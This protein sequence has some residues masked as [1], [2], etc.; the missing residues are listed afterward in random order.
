M[1]LGVV[2]ASEIQSGHF[3]GDRG[4]AATCHCTAIPELARGSP[5]RHWHGGS[6]A[7][8]PKSPLSPQAQPLRNTE[9][10][11]LRAGRK[12][13]VANREWHMGQK[14]SHLS[15]GH[16]TLPWLCCS[17][18]IT[19]QG[20]RDWV[21]RPLPGHFSSLLQ[22]LSALPLLCSSFGPKTSTPLF[23]G[24]SD[25]V[26]LSSPDSLPPAQDLPNGK[27]EMISDRAKGSTFS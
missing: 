20:T 25:A 19:T 16:W 8:D 5:P 10:E 14:P 24:L 1:I 9:E 12:G 18:T 7:G 15:Q 26:P 11:S 6:A 2:K 21:S 27:C 22:P 23:P 17:I 13:Q 4:A 3:L